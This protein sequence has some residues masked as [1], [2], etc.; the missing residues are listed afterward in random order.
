MNKLEVINQYLEDHDVQTLSADGFDSAILGVCN[1]RIAYSVAKCVRILV[2]RDHM[3]PQEALE[4][5]EFNVEGAYV[6]EKTP[7]WI[8]DTMFEGV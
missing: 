4:Y 2:D 5:F 7:L 6:G 1:D 8:D 3:S